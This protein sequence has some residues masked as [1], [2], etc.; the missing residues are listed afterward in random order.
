MLFP[1]P[2]VWRIWSEKKIE[3]ICMSHVIVCNICSFFS[4]T[5]CKIWTACMQKISKCRDNW[6]L[7]VVTAISRK[8]SACGQREVSSVLVSWNLVPIHEL[9][10]L[11]RFHELLLRVSHTV[12]GSLCFIFTII[13]IFAV[14]ILLWFHSNRFHTRIPRV[15]IS[16]SSTLF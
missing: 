6:I 2:Y 7:W 5:S 4:K 1:R 14:I 3:I 15:S 12:K 8:F 11:S 16:W 10:L 13:V 9:C